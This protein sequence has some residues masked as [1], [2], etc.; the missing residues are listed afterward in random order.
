MWKGVSYI[1]WTN[2]SFAQSRYKAHTPVSL[3]LCSPCDSFV[4]PRPEPLSPLKGIVLGI[5]QRIEKF[6][7]DLKW[8]M[9]VFRHYEP[10]YVH[11]LK[12]MWQD[13]SSWWEHHCPAQSFTIALWDLSWK[14]IWA[15]PDF[16]K[17]RG[18]CQTLLFVVIFCLSTEHKHTAF[19]WENNGNQRGP[20]YFALFANI[21]SFCIHR[22]ILFSFTPQPPSSLPFSPC[23]IL[24]VPLQDFPLKFLF[25]IRHHSCINQN[26]ALYDGQ[27]HW[28]SSLRALAQEL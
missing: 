7:L 28:L 9:W 2:L 23:L 24:A 8:V 22:A 25:L 1:I 15:F 4:A 19:L 12:Q 26:L 21:F 14:A 3:R 20:L 16:D 6:L 5:S 11:T 13:P 27:A 18:S 10:N 17:T